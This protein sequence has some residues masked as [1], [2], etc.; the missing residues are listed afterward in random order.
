[1][2]PCANTLKYGVPA[3]AGLATGGYALSQG[4]DPGSA[5][6]AAIA[7]GLGGAAGL[8]GARAL[9]GKYN[10]T[11]ILAAQKQVSNLGNKVGDVARN[12]PEKGLRRG[13]AN[14]AADAVSAVDTRL[15]GSP[16]AGISA[17]LPF[18]TQNVQRNIG[19]GLAAGLVPVSAGLAGLG[20]IALGGAIGE[21]GTPGFQ[22]GII[23][24]EAYQSNN[25]PGARQSIPTRS[26][27][28]LQYA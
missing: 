7:G 18:P 16:D 19:R 25:M 24:P 10:P 15:F 6:L 14:V 21:M 2:K 23:D 3:A 20:G 5:G 4:E 9:A 22:Q 1:V 11:L 27:S 12:L 8:L 17:A 28:G 26:I 13:A